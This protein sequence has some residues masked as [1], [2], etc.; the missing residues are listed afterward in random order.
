MSKINTHLD[1]QVLVNKYSLD[2]IEEYEVNRETPW[3]NGLL[4]ELE[5]ENDDEAEFPAAEMVL[6]AQI[7]RK[8]NTYLK[9]HLVVR[10]QLKAHFHMPCGR[11]LFPLPQEL[12]LNLS[13]AFLHE[14]L[15]K[16]PEYAEAT[17]VYADG[18]EMELYFY[19]KGMADLQE[20]I[21]E[22]IYIEVTPFPRCDGECKNPVLF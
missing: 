22:Q 9:D 11:C 12:D 3:I 21:H 6:K 13:A 2:I 15:Q 4:V 19:L 17:T 18:Q 1:P 16:L 10:A 20:F 5:E 7:T 8:T 14:A